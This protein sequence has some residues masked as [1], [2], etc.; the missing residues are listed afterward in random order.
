MMMSHSRSI[1]VLEF[2]AQH[3]EDFAVNPQYNDL[4]V[5]LE[6]LT[7]WYRSTDESDAYFVTVGLLI[8]V[9][10]STHTI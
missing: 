4:H 5:G 10:F 7:K 3:W 1:T 2:L 8:Y 9:P 6:N